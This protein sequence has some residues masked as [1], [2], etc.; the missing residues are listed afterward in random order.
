MPHLLRS[1][2]LCP[3]FCLD[4]ESDRAM[5][6]AVRPPEYIVF[7]GSVEWS[8]QALF[9]PSTSAKRRLRTPFTCTARAAGT[10]VFQYDNRIRQHA[11]SGTPS[12]ALKATQTR[13]LGTAEDAGEPG[14]CRHGRAPWQ[15]LIMRKPGFRAPHERGAGRFQAFV[16]KGRRGPR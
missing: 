9:S 7:H 16:R 3:A 2:A 6:G 1:Y 15:S 14:T 4:C 10:V 11:K 5:S 8:I 13:A 12:S